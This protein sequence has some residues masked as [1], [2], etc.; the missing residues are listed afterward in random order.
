MP[1]RKQM[2]FSKSMARNSTWSG[3]LLLSIAALQ[4]LL[5]LSYWSFHRGSSRMVAGEWLFVLS[6]PVYV[7]VG[8]GAKRVPLC[9]A[10]GFIIHLGLFAYVDALPAGETQALRDGR[11][12]EVPIFLLFLWALWAAIERERQA[13]G[14]PRMRLHVAVRRGFHLA[15]TG[16]SSALLLLAFLDLNFMVRFSFPER[17][18]GGM[19]H[20]FALRARIDSLLAAI[21]GCMLTLSVTRL[22]RELA[23]RELAV[24][25]EGAARSGDSP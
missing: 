23:R 13:R 2:T 4:A 20:D 11:V 1:R 7:A 19:A 9:T 14:L 12:L 6:A 18:L 8:L 22:W 24:S 15:L 5:G 16:I 21:G 10:V 3:A 25:D 17:M